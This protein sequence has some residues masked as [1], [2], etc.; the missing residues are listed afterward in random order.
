MNR[1]TTFAIALIVVMGAIGGLWPATAQESPAVLVENT[2]YVLAR[3]LGPR[4]NLRAAEGFP[5]GNT[6]RGR[7]PLHHGI[8]LINPRG[9]PVLAA[10]DGVVYYAGPDTDRLFGPRAN[11]YGNVIV[12]RHGTEGD[13]GTLFT[14]YGHVDTVEVQ[15]DTPVTAGQRIG[16]VGA[17]GIA[18][19]AHLHFEVRIGNPDDYNAVRNPELW[20][21]PRPGTGMVMGRIFGPDGSR[22]YGVRFTIGN[23]SRFYYSFSY[24]DPAPPSDSAFGEHFTLTDIPAGCYSFRVRGAYDAPLCIEAGKTYF[25]DVRLAN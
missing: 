24:E 25:M 6:R 21:A 8:D 3:P 2:H 9:T 19:G 17:K 4:A 20:Y 22:A 10:A 12:I 7:S 16:T 14:L 11:F 1:K 23:A 15:T 18:L 13:G 5:Y